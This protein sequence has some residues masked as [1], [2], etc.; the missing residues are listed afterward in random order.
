[1]KLLLYI[2]ICVLIIFVLITIKIEGSNIVNDNLRQLVKIASPRCHI[3]RID[4]H[5]N[6]YDIRSRYERMIV[7]GCIK[8]KFDELTKHLGKI[9]NINRRGGPE[10]F[11]EFSTEK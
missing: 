8:P 7:T 5:I 10:N 11:R 1:M 4:D 2:S 6:K 3:L 9:K